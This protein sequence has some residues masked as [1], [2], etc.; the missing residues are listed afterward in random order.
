MIDVTGLKQWAGLAGARAGAA[1]TI[2]GIPYDGS[3]V[4]RKGAAQAPERIRSLSAVMPPVTE[5]GRLLAGLSVHDLGDITA[6][7][8]IEQEG[9]PIADRLAEL[10]PASPPTVI[11][12]A[13]CT[14]PPPLP[15]HGPRHPRPSAIRADRHP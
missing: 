13:P 6:G 7:S 2:A 12:G 8:S 1:V 5:E 10:P 15:A 11:A 4:Y 14:A 9:Q 3:A